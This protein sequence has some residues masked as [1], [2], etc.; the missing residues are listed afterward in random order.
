MRE[1]LKEVAHVAVDVSTLTE[2]AD[3]WEEWDLTINTLSPQIKAIEDPHHL[4]RRS[5]REESQLWAI[6]N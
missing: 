3:Q 5:R 2:G 1:I 6:L 4:P